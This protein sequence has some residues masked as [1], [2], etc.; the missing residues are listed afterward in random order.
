LLSVKNF[1]TKTMEKLNDYM[2]LFRFEP[3]ANY[4]PT[5]AELAEQKKAWGTFIGGIA[6][7]AKL[8]STHQLGFTGKQVSADMRI[9]DGIHLANEVTLGGNMVVKSYNLD[10]AVEIAKACPILKMGGS[11]EVRSILAM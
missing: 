3:N 10:E 5:E 8:V 9:T 7:Q 1:K 2:L 4:Q 6:A 11:V